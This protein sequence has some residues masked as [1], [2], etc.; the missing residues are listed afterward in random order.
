MTIRMQE[1]RDE[2]EIYN[3]QVPTDLTFEYN[4]F[5]KKS[6]LVGYAWP[7][8]TLTFCYYYGVALLDATSK[9]A[10]YA[11]THTSKTMQVLKIARLETRIP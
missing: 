6:I 7:G 3:Y 4:K 2:S 9:G 8:L 10:L 1:C 11:Q 5:I